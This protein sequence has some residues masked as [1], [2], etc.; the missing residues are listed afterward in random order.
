VG[1]LIFFLS[2]LLKVWGGLQFVVTV[3]LRVAIIVRYK[4][5]GVLVLTAFWG[6]LFQL[7]V[8]PFNWIDGVMEDVAHRVSRMLDNEAMREPN[9]KETQEHGL[10]D[11]RKKYLWWLSSREGKVSLHRQIK[12]NQGTQ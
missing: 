5:C 8:S 9:G 12:Q 10:E 2:L 7:A 3:C 6:M 4:G 1:P 11:L